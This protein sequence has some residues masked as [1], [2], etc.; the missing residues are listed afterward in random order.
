MRNLL[1]IIRILNKKKIAKIEILDEQTLRQKG[2]LF[3]KFYE[4]LVTGKIETD[5]DAIRLLYGTSDVSNAKYRQVK[6][7]LRRRILNTLFFIDV[8]VPM[9]SNYD[10]AL[11]NCNKEWAIVEILLAYEARQLA[12]SLARQI[13]NT[14]LKF[15]FTTLLLQSGRL[16][17][18][19]AVAQENEKDFHYYKEHLQRCLHV[20]AIEIKSE[21]LVQEAL[22]LYNRT[23]CQE[24]CIQRIE[25]IGNTLVQL[26][27][28]EEVLTI[29]YWMY[30]TW[31]LYYELLRDYDGMLEVCENGEKLLREK[32]DSF[33]AH[34]KTFFPLKKL[35]AYLHQN[36]YVEGK[37]HAEAVLPYLSES[38]AEWLH[39]M[40]YYLLLSFYT[41]NY[42]NAL[43]IFNLVVNASI[44]KNLDETQ[45]E[46]WEIIEA[47]LYYFIEQQGLSVALLSRQRRKVFKMSDFITRQA[48]YQH[49]YA[50][51]IVQRVA[52]QILF[53]FQRRSY[54]GIAERIGQ[55]NHLTKY[56]LKRPGYER[57]YAFVRLLSQLNKAEF[58]LKNLR[59]T[60]KFVQ[61]LQANPYFY[62]DKVS[63]LEVLPY[64]K[65]WQ[66]ICKYLEQPV[67]KVS[68]LSKPAKA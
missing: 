13:F 27:E 21:N 64:E 46:E 25:E 44:F 49:P 23:D 35:L 43:A 37:A 41:D 68:E 54:Q 56:E 45:R 58:S 2:S 20:M 9:A 53:L 15:Q 12:F 48:N 18:E 42:I 55:L 26:G 40:K 32:P 62:Q 34:K 36:L 4:G 51:L 52:L 33:G 57:P 50:N 39:F 6:S 7:R 65:L 14:A 11:F 5:E 66:L 17:Q 8:N 30:V 60:E 28:E 31:T 10:Q 1:D 16:L 24:N 29:S 19:Y 38:S 59:N 67:I 63:Q 61:Q 47:T 22:L 3:G